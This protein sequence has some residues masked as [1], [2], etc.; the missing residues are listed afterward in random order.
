MATAWT[1]SGMKQYARTSMR[2]S[3]AARRIC[4]TVMATVAASVKGRVRLCAQIVK[5]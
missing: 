4:N 2:S 1:W 5:E 3:S